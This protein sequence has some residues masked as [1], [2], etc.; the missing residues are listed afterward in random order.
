[1]NVIDTG[2][3]SAA[4]VGRGVLV[5]VIDSGWDRSSHDSRVRPGV[6]LVDSADE[7]AVAH[8]NDA[9]D[10]EGHGTKCGRLVLEMAPGAEIL[11][12][13]VFGRRLE[14]SAEHVIQALT[15]A[16]EFGAHVANMSLATSRRDLI[17]PLYTACERAS[18][19]GMLIVAAADRRSGRGYPAIFENVIGVKAGPFGDARHLEYR[20]HA[21]IEVRAS[22]SLPVGAA[23]GDTRPLTL[24][25][26][27]AAARVA[28]VMA[29]F[30]ETNPSAGIDAARAWLP[31]RAAA[32]PRDPSL[33]L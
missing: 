8:S 19:T 32:S 2:E 3:P 27:F 16:I 31:T 6:N 28:G 11:P 13:R 1:M 22:G 12:I 29:E 21:S 7:L 23:G 15:I 17:V 10:V 4:A 9:N 5:A 18:R 25:N 14:T 26:S 30:R 33:R 20:R 24:R